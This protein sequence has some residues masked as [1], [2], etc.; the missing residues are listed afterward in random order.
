[1]W[2]VLCKSLYIF[3][4][5]CFLFLYTTFRSKQQLS[6]PFIPTFPQT[7]LLWTHTNQISLQY[8]NSLDSWSHTSHTTS[9]ALPPTLSILCSQFP[10]KGH[11]KTQIYRLDPLEQCL[12][13]GLFFLHDHIPQWFYPMQHLLLY[14]LLLLP[15]YS[16]TESLAS[17]TMM[18]S[19]TL[20]LPDTKFCWLFIPRMLDDSYSS[21]VIWVVTI[22]HCY[23]QACEENVWTLYISEADLPFAVCWGWSTNRNFWPPVTS[24]RVLCNP[25]CIH[26]KIGI[27]YPAGWIWCVCIVY[28]TQ[29]VKKKN[30]SK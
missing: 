19:V 13:N 27:D 2:S 9:T 16:Y 5:S 29:N 7:I 10:I 11:C 1:M 15:M 26:T 18:N 14:C 6:I 30:N 22:V 12:V 23:L 8:T 28:Y 24:Q 21:T 3:L 4:F 17:G 20:W 25:T